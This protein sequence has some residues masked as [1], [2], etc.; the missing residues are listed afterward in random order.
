MGAHGI[1]DM[2]VR[3]HYLYFGEDE[4]YRERP[5]V[6]V[7]TKVLPDSSNTHL[8]PYTEKVIDS[9]NG[10]KILT[11]QDVYDAL[12]GNHAEDGR[13]DFHVIRAVGEGRPLV[14]ERL[15]GPGSSPPYHGRLQRHQ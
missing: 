8:Q 7:L 5:E 13:K 2:Q 15:E 9:I 10:V 12:H 14:I 3:Y 1:D 4:I 6:V 11:L